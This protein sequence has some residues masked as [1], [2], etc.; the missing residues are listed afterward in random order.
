MVAT[1]WFCGGKLIWGGD[2]TREDYCMRGEG[3]VTNLQC[4]EC[5][6]EA[7][8]IQAEDEEK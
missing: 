7:L 6:A 5:G 4:S 8:F 2:H 3:L 1:C